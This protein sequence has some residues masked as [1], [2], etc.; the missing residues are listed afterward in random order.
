[1][2]EKKTDMRSFVLRID[3]KTMDQ[4]EV[5]A[6]EEFRSVNGQLQWII[7]D[8]LRKYGRMPDKKE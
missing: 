1:M 2:P 3:S 6:A 4:I 7:A 5:W 8:S